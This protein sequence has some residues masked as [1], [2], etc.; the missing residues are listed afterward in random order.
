MT[1][2]LC[3]CGSKQ[4]STKQQTTPQVGKADS[5][6]LATVDLARSAELVELLSDCRT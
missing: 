3:G 2:G 6:D 4:T 5:G 1:H